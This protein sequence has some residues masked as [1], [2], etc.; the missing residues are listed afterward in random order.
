M[1]KE[2]SG[3]DPFIT[4]DPVRQY[5][6]EISKHPLLTPEEERETATAYIIGNQ[7]TEQLDEIFEKDP[8][9]DIEEE[10]I[11]ALQDLSAQG[12]QAKEKM[13]VSNLR[14]VVSIAKR[15]GGNGLDLLD[16]IQEGNKGLFRAVEKFDPEKGFKFS[17]YATW[18]IKQ[19][20]TRAYQTTGSAIRVPNHLY[21]RQNQLKSAKNEL[22]RDQIEVTDDSLSDF[23]GWS[24][25]EVK[26]TLSSIDIQNLESLN[27]ERGNREG[28]VLEDTIAD[29]QAL[30]VG[31]IVLKSIIQENIAAALIEVGLDDREQFVINQR[32]GM[33]GAIKAMTLQEIGDSL[34]PPVSRERVRQIEKGILNKLRNLKGFRELLLDEDFS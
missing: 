6:E 33:N 10:S 20:I 25:D 28:Y 16:L 29:T 22:L 32:Y 31:E 14:L 7:A 30:S 8:Y 26:K 11:I 21:V 34:D 12:K 18:W 5:M 9:A 19:G 13:I 4:Q 2:V 27:A 1:K 17:T 23:L 24:V 15:Y 3:T